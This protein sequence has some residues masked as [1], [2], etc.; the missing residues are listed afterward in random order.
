MTFKTGSK[1][2]TLDSYEQY[3]RDALCHLLLESYS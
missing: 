1:K 3:F 2:S